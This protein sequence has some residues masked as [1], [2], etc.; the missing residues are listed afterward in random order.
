MTLGVVGDGPAVD[1]VVA[2]CGD[3]DCEPAT[4]R[5]GD[6][7]AVDLA[8]VVDDVGA[9]A[10]DAANDAARECGTPW[11]AVELGGLG[12][13]ALPNLSAAV[14]GFG[15]DTGCFDCLRGRVSA[16]A[17]ETGGNPPTDP[18]VARYAGALAGREAARMN[19]G[20]ESALL[21]GVVEVPH[22]ERRFLP[23]PECSCSPARDRT[24]DLTHNPRSIEDAAGAAERGLDGRVGIVREVGEAESFPAPYYLATSCDTSGFSDVAAP[25]Q[26]AGV[27][28]DW[29][30]AF[31]KALGE[32]YERYSAGV[33]RT[34]TFEYGTVTE[35]AGAIAPE[36]F[37]TAP[38]FDDSDSGDELAWVPGRD[39][40]TGESVQLPASFVQFPPPERQYRPAT[41]TGLGLGNSTV[42]AVLSG[43][44][45]VVE[46]DAAMLAWYS[47][48]DPL[49]LTVEDEGYETLAARADSEG[50]ETTALLLTQDVDVPVV[51][52]AV[53]REDGD[54]PQFATGMGASL[55]P[56]AAARAALEEAIQNWMELRGMGR[57]GAA[58]ESGAIGYYAGFPEEAL[59][60]LEA[61]AAVPAASVAPDDAPVGEA[62][63]DRLLEQ[64]DD[65]DLDAYAARL[66]PPDVEQVGFEAVRVLVP[67]AQPL[68]TDEPYFGERAER[69]PRDLGFDPAPN[70]QHHPFP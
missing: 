8:V 12:G 3:V 70:R 48:F 37:V 38:S 4:I 42:E 59:A 32:A 27:S 67:S 61:E 41:T 9:D 47:T 45:E 14:S 2:A 10:F 39:L 62:E 28:V 49:A 30:A 40:R 22:A 43:L 29:N 60:F 13:H 54:W 7:G 68:F 56:A 65:A 50:L 66:T 33:Y 18:T 57:S 23:L 25:R 11:L 63:L 35:V 34:E 53:H 21:G 5:P 64:L 15:R 58:D 16:N 69:V 44:Y 20:G 31:V 36:A 51:G 55:D 17:E 46:R 6:L 26:S 1:A 24:L 19:A 52:C